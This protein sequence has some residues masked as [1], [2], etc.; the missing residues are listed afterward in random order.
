MADLTSRTHWK[1]ELMNWKMSLKKISRL[2]H[3]GNIKIENTE[4]NA[5]EIYGHVRI[6]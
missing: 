5:Y 2:S 6:V 3:K 4:E 1:R